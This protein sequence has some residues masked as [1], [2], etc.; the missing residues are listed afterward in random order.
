MT[1]AL[2][3]CL[4]PSILSWSPG[5]VCARCRRAVNSL[6]TM[7]LTS[8]DLPLPLTPVT[9]V[10]TPNGNSTSIFLR[11][12]SLAPRTTSLRS[13]STARRFLGTDIFSAPDKYRPV[14][15]AGFC[16]TSAGVPAATI[17]PPC[18]PAPG[19]TSTKKSAAAIVSSSCSTTN[20]VLPRSR[21]CLSVLINRSLSRWCKPIDGSSNTYSTPCSPEPICVARRIRCASPPLRVLA[22]R[23]SSR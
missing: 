23:P 9:S 22:A 5:T 16:A 6:A 4:T 10:I 13:F 18:T 3:N 2:S 19:P 1:I 17:S 12:F 20:T 7:S 21:K 11:L 15:L 14:I 8:V